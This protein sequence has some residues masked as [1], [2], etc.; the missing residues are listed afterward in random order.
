MMPQDV[1]NLIMAS[2]TTL[3]DWEPNLPRIIPVLPPAEA[4]KKP[5]IIAREGASVQD[6][7]NARKAADKA[8]AAVARGVEEARQATEEQGELN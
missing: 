3:R 5:S 6:F 8:V 7:A 2:R 4:R 1:R